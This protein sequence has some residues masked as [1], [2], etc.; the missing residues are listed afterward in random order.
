MYSRS[1]VKTSYAVNKYAHPDFILIGTEQKYVWF[2]NTHLVETDNRRLEP[3]K[4]LL[5]L[6]GGKGL[7]KITEIP[8]SDK[9]TD[10]NVPSP[11]NDVT[12]PSDEIVLQGKYS[13]EYETRISGTQSFPR[14]QFETE[15][16][17]SMGD[18]PPVIFEPHSV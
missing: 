16:A 11:I 5:M 1:S 8:D 7:Y 4:Y 18:V 2:G 13:I 6:P 14:Y 10:A 3:G 12:N 17:L 15:D 9:F